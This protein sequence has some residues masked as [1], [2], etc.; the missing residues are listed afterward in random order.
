MRVI[1]LLPTLSY[2]D[3]VGNDTIAIDSI[4]KELG[5]DTKIY[6]ENID[7]RIAKGLVKNVKRM[8]ELQKHDVVI[9]HLSTGT[10][11]NEQ[12]SSFN[13]RKLIV[14][15]NITPPHFFKGYSQVSE[16]LCS[17][18]IKGVQRLREVAE[19][20]W[21]DS[22]YNRK[23]LLNYGYKCNI[24]IIPIVI[25][26]DN[27]AK[28]PKQ[29]IINKYRDD[30]VN[31]VFVGRVVPNKKQED[32][33]KTFYYYKKYINFK[34][35]LFLVGSYY[36]MEK[37]YEKL[38]MYVQELK[39]SDVHFTGQIKFNELLSY[40]H[41]A[42]VFLCMSEHEGFCIPLIEAMYFGI[43]I[44]AYDD[45]GVRDTLNGAGFRLETKDCIIAAEMIDQ[46]VSKKEIKKYLIDMQNKR[47]EEFSYELTKNKII[48]CLKKWI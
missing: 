45:T 37:Y 44:I 6:A 38:R 43:P 22:A 20:C 21:A 16:V 13:C 15:H 12:L 26:F 24:D 39:L 18:G 23:E 4:I 36:G 27:Y 32:I 35:R 31:I 42:D 33:I 2:G 1:Q 28:R 17:E 25:P 48:S 7:H 5:Y 41:L 29:L 19:Y 9:Y 10:V 40:Y 34:S 3:A 30:Y 11:L 46:V 8:P 47:L 14:Y